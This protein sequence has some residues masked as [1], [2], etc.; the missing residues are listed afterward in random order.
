MY[1]CFSKGVISKLIYY[2]LKAVQGIASYLE[3]KSDFSLAV[4]CSFTGET[5]DK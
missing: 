3:Y 1:K 4:V 5:F 2:F